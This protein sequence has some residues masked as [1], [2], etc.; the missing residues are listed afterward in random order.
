MADVYEQEHGVPIDLSAHKTKDRNH[1]RGDGADDL[2]GGHART[3]TETNGEF[4]MGAIAGADTGRDA[5]FDVGLDSQSFLSL[6]MDFSPDFFQD[7][8]WLFE[9]S[10][11]TGMVADG[12]GLETA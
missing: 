4:S 6:D 2:T 1:G 7:P 11:W 8:E 3:G 9:S 12:T 10:D 5:W